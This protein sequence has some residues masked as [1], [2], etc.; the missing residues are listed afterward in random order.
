MDKIQIT[1]FFIAFVMIGLLLY[2]IINVHLT[3]KHMSS[4]IIVLTD[5]IQHI[6]EKRFLRKICSE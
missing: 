1:L 2:Y 5:I 3:L 4:N 6:C